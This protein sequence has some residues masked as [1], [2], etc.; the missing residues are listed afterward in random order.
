VKCEDLRVVRAEYPRQASRYTTSA[1]SG[2]L[3]KSDPAQQQGQP[4]P[5][6]A[7]DR[8]RAL[9]GTIRNLTCLGSQNI[10]LLLTRRP[11][12][13]TGPSS[14]VCDPVKGRCTEVETPLNL[15]DFLVIAHGGHVAWCGEWYGCGPFQ[16]LYALEP[17]SKG[18]D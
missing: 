8:N 4:G 13:P 3:V 10:N 9:E 17:T 15:H 1:M 2:I 7:P 16:E 14:G 5:N 11:S 6:L 18:P 12:S